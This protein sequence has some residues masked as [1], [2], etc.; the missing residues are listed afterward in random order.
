MTDPTFK[1]LFQKSRVYCLQQLQYLTSS[2][3]KAKEL[4]IEAITKYWIMC[5]KNK[6]KNIKN[7][8]QYILK[9]AKHIW[10]DRNKKK[11][12]EELN[13]EDQL[14]IHQ[15]KLIDIFDENTFNRLIQKENEE[16]SA[17]E[18]QKRKSALRRAFKKL[19]PK[20]QKLLIAAFTYEKSNQEIEKELG[21]NSANVVKATK[22]R[23]KEH[24][25]ALC[26]KE[27]NQIG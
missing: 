16:I 22:Y 26:F 10:Y 13:D 5:K 3:P 11:K 7:P 8:E 15:N 12:H 20:C 17:H 25:K 19:K 21:Y 2:K 24:L 6:N 23:C 9:I 27:Y 4:F 18:F 14:N 1:E